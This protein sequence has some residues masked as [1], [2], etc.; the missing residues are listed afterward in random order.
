MKIIVRDRDG[1]A[2]VNL[3]NGLWA[4]LGDVI[5]GKQYAEAWS[6]T[7]VDLENEFGPLTVEFET[8]DPVTART[9]GR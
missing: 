2:Y 3:G 5:K 7:Y 9:L 1:D 8:R 6:W 4:M